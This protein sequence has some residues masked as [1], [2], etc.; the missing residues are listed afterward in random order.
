MGAFSPKFI[1]YSGMISLI[2]LRRSSLIFTGTNK[3][4]SKGSLSLTY[5]VEQV[6]YLASFWKGIFPL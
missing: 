2:R 6:V 5:A 4:V 1:I 3:Q